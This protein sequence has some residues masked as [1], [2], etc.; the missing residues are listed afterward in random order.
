VDADFSALQAAFRE[1]VFAFL[2]RKEKITQEVVESMRAW[3]HSG[4]Q[5]NW[6]RRFAPDDRQAI[7]GLL[8]TMDR[9]PVSLRRLTYRAEEG[10]VHNQGTK[11]HPRLG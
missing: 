6:G 1:R 5:V 10:L 3:Q 4:F 2:L 8:G 9:P 7:E 11:L